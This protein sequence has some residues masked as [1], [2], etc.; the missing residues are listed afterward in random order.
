[1]RRIEITNWMYDN[2]CKAMNG[3]NLEPIATKTASGYIVET[4]KVVRH[5]TKAYLVDFRYFKKA[6]GYTVDMQE[7]AGFEFWIPRMAIIR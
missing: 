2:L 5:T 3:Y 1:M 7:Y 4:Q 6:D